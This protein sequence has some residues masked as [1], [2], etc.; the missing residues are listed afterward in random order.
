[1]KNLN[2]P[3]YFLLLTF[4]LF[5]NASI[6]NAVTVTFSYTGSAQTWTVP[7]GVTLITVDGYGAMGGHGASDRNGRGGLGGRVQTNISVTPGTTLNIYVGGSG[8]NTTSNPGANYK[9]SY[10]PYEAGNGQGGFN[11]GTQGGQTSAGAGGGATDIR[12]GGTA[13]SNRI[14]VAG[15]GGGGANQRR[16]SQPGGDGGHGGGTTGG[17]GSKGGSGGTNQ[18]SSDLTRG[19]NA[20]GGGAG[21][22]G[23]TSSAGG[24]GGSVSGSDG[25]LGIGGQG[26]NSGR[27]GGG[28]GGGYYG[29]GGGG[30]KNGSDAG[31][32]GGGG[33]SYC[34]PTYC[35]S[36]THTQGYTTATG[37]GSLE[38]TYDTTAPTLSSS[39]PADN[40]T[41]VAIDANIVLN[42]SESVDAETGYITIKK[43]SDDSTVESFSVTGSKVSGSGSSQITVNPSSNFDP[44]IEYYVLIDATAFD[45]ISSNSYA[46]ISSTTALSFTTANV[47][48]TLSS[49]TPAD[50]A[51]D[52]ARDANIVFNFSEIVD[53]KTGNITIKKTSDD[54]TFETIDVTSS[55]V[56]GTGTTQIT[57]NPTSNFEAETEYYVLIDA[58]AFDDVS[59]GSY[60]GISSTTALS[61]T[62]ES[63]VDPTTVKDVVG[64]I[65]VQSHLAKNSITQST[66]TVSSRLSY[67]RQNKDNQNLS[68]QNIK[69]DFGNAI[70]TSL[71]NE[72]LAKNDKSI[73]PDNW[74]SWSEGSLSSSKIGD[75]TGS[76]SSETDAQALAFGFDTKLNDSDLL[77]FAIQY[78]KSDTDIGSSGS[79]TDSENINISI[80]RTRPLDDDNFIEGMFGVGLIESDLK[81]ISGANTLTGSRSGTQIF[82]SI[83]YGKT[84]DKGDFNLTPIGRID[85][86]YTELDAYKE[87]GTDALSYGKQTIESGLAS[88]GLELSD[89]V[90]FNDNKLK[91]FGSI[92]YGMDFSNSSEAKMN[93]VSDTST[94]YTYTQGANSNHLITSVIGFEYITKDNLEIISSYKRI[95]GNESEQTDILNVSV[96]F[97]SKR[98][99]E[100]AMSID[101]SEDLNAGFDITKNVNG[102]DIN[103]YANR[104]L[105]E[106]SDQTA[107]VSLSRSF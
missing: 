26:G 89:I 42:F 97:K 70:L 13:L 74:S 15:G 71:T 101:G 2:F 35:S 8:G 10:N 12:F 25:T 91:P 41:A 37:N 58:T 57:I 85:L 81:R 95:Q 100:Y 73:I 59:S 77:G 51:T 55:N 20:T 61:F 54:S 99:T 33:S 47:L 38:I 11:G 66:I 88:V 30:H 31:G 39:S 50:N 64:S 40:A 32:G 86:G 68:K 80:Y 3:K 52:V 104:S 84:L 23:G 46:G 4:T 1:M 103:F 72:L 106:N 24:A 82:G 98:E 9:P 94:I 79:S 102:F 18:S 63:M 107:N 93:Y 69:L 29:G 75:R 90:K 45:D 14:Y 21:G 83:N 6:A 36:T 62:T 7:S 67:L 65:D 27:H 60:T 34:D 105:S 44:N 78:G 87:T 53:V 16:E 49:S 17:A 56:T 92:E 76:S 22:G 43:T 96:N 5:L 19:P 48:P 28:G